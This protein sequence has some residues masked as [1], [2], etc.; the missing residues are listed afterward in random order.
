MPSIGWPRTAKRRVD[1][2]RVGR[3]RDL[4]GP[5]TREGFR[6]GYRT[7]GFGQ[8]IGG[9]SEFGLNPKRAISAEKRAYPSQ[10]TG[11]PPLSV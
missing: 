11:S 5:Q 8:S 6:N 10:S 1:S 3:D 9:E 7:G 4:V 2:P